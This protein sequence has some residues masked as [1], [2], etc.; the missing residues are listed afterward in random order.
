MDGF[1]SVRQSATI[2][3]AQKSVDSSQPTGWKRD[4]NGTFD[5]IRQSGL[6]KVSIFALHFFRKASTFGSLKRVAHAF[7]PRSRCVTAPHHKP[8]HKLEL[9]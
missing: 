7:M 2:A 5:G 8:H 4:P 1:H 6:W 9:K 3:L